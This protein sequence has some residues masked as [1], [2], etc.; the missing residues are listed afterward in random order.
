MPTLIFSRVGA[1][2]PCSPRAGAHGSAARLIPYNP[3]PLFS[4]VGYHADRGVTSLWWGHLC[5]ASA[6]SPPSPLPLHAVLGPDA[7]C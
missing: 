4:V 5:T 7:L 6:V 2:P 1:C 3:A